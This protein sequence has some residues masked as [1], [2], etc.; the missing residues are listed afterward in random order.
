MQ[1]MVQTF[2]ENLILFNLNSLLNSLHI[3]NAHFNYHLQI[4]IIS[5]VEILLKSFGREVKDIK[6]AIC[7]GLV[8]RSILEGKEPFESAEENKCSLN[9]SVSAFFKFRNH[10]QIGDVIAVA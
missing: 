8:A 5:S 9:F 3:K 2:T 1:Q 4:C 10:Q 6:F 7:I